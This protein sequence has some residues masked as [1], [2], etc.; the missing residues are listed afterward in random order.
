MHTTVTL[1]ADAPAQLLPAR[2]LMA[3]TLASHIILVPLGVALPLITLVMHHRGLRRNDPV[4]LLLARRWSAV[5][6][7]QFAVGVVTGTVLSFEF[8]LLWPGLMGTW[9][10]V[11]GIGFGVEAWAFFLEAVLIAIYLYGWRRLKP[12]THFLLGLPLPAAALLGAFGILAAN[13]WMNTPQGFTLDADGKPADVHI[14]SAIFTPMFGPQYWHFVVAMLVTAGYVVAGVYAVG[15]LRG[16]RDRYHRLGFTVPFTLAAVFTPVQMLLGD[17]I[18]RSVFHK[19]PVKFAAT[20][21]VWRTGT[22]VPEYLFG[23]LHP[24]GTV[25]GGIKIPQLDSVLAGFRPATKVTGLTSVPASDRPTP[26]QATLAHGAFD[27]M[28]VIGSLLLLL[29]LWYGWC[30]LRRRRLPRSPWFFRGAACAGVASVVAVECGWVTAEVGRQP[31][32][33]YQHMR[34]GEAVTATRSTSL[35]IM[36]G[37]VMAV[38]VFIF[39]S[40]LAV[41][42]K[43]RTGW[44]LADARPAAEERHE[45]PEADT[46]YGPRAPV[47]AGDPPSSGTP[48]QEPAEGGRP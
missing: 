13:S 29:A 37:L 9:G 5:M 36:L 14:W 25:S 47:P 17:S 24:D 35:W 32:I 34:I 31:W 12:R 18:A 41:L 23:R 45:G 44:R 48:G 4:A 2:Q 43:M 1:L 26:A 11:F 40:L 10:G 7:V 28:V 6:A 20:E 42:L 46:P 39:G 19:Q 33:V 21:I 30:R 8:G 22:H 16:R 27:L 38:Y 15:W 3:F